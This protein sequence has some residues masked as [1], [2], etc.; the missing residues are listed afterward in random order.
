MHIL[1]S[2]QKENEFSAKFSSLNL[3]VSKLFRLRYFEFEIP[4]CLSLDT[5]S[6]IRPSIGRLMSPIIDLGGLTVSPLKIIISRMRRKSRNSSQSF[7][8]VSIALHLFLHQFLPHCFSGIL[9]ETPPIPINST[10]SKRTTQ[11][12]KNPDYLH[13]HYID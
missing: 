5:G 1:Q 3:Q 6:V 11:N 7:T 4:S 13:S 2:S 9:P 8:F 10:H 12:I